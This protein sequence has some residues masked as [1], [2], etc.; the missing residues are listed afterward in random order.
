MGE[1]KGRGEGRS[2][3]SKKNSNKGNGELVA[4]LSSGEPGSSIMAFGSRDDVDTKN[5]AIL[6][7]WRNSPGRTMFQRTF[8]ADEVAAGSSDISMR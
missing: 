2:R 3:A 7:K 1:G 8:D 6:E 4:P 5:E